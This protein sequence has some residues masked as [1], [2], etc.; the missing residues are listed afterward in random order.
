MKKKLELE[1]VLYEDGVDYQSAAYGARGCEVVAVLCALVAHTAK[2]FYTSEKEQDIFIR[3]TAR[4]LLKVQ[5]EK[6]S[7]EE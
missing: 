7:V 4:A 6:G 2:H 3:E 5:D 1:A